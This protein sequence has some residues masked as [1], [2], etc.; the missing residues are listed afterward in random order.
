MANYKVRYIFSENASSWA[1]VFYMTG[2]DATTAG[3]QAD[4]VGQARVMLLANNTNLVGC[5]IS[6]ESVSHD[7]LLVDPSGWQKDKVIGTLSSDVPWTGFLC[8]LG[9]GGVYNRSLI[10]RG[11]PDSYVSGDPTQ[12]GTPGAWKTN[13][14]KL[15]EAM[16]ANN[17][18]IRGQARGADNPAIPI[19]N[20]VSALGGLN[21]LVTGGIAAP[22]AG[23][24]VRISGVQGVTG[25]NG[26]VFTVLTPAGN[27][28]TLA[29]S[30][31]GIYLGQG[32]AQPLKYIYV[33]ITTGIV[34]RFTK[35]D[36]KAGGPFGQRGRRKKHN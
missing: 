18:C 3:K 13:F 27:N 14:Q 22:V 31:L 11:V 10:A 24:Q 32:K 25:L 9:S 28:F 8:R 4:A 19:V 2:A 34:Q 15:I 30:F 20:V 17:F 1:E 16:K 23:S 35:R 21:C 26:R 12:Q 36:T 5:T 7:A 29:V 33:P 6:D